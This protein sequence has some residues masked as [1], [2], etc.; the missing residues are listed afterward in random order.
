MSNICLI[1]AKKRTLATI[2]VFLSL[3]T[4]MPVQ[5]DT[6][7]IILTRA[8][9]VDGRTRVVLETSRPVNYQML[10]LK[11][12]E[13]LVLDMQDVKLDETL[14]ALSGRIRP[15]D[16]YIRQVRMAYFKPGVVRVVFDL[17]VEVKPALFTLV[18][19]GEYQDRLVLDIYPL[20]GLPATVPE[21]S[22][23]H[24]GTQLQKQDIA[25]PQPAA[26]VIT[27]SKPES[28]PPDSAAPAA[29]AK[30]PAGTIMKTPVASAE[31]NADSA[32]SAAPPRTAAEP[33]AQFNAKGNAL[34]GAGLL[35][36]TLL[37]GILLLIFL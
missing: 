8:Y 36:T 12:P 16:P 10:M 7:I 9:H 4:G 1:M 31:T 3:C 24:V 17:K 37:A 30:P 22:A 5:A 34:P 21:K 15:D 26:S 2:A 6:A 18:P 11:N 25:I 35:M 23:E 20:N 27:E 19:M 28:I 33:S 13:R 32:G 29:P 14:K